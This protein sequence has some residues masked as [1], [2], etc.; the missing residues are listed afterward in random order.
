M[1]LVLGEPAVGTLPDNVIRE[2]ATVSVVSALVN[3]SGVPALVQITMLVLE[4]PQLRH[5]SA[6][7]DHYL[8][9][10]LDTIHRLL[11]PRKEIM[12]SVLKNISISLQQGSTVSIRLE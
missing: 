4:T 1:A 9:R 12:R 3:I 6:P 8:P 11:G 5:R 2:A 7:V 10:G